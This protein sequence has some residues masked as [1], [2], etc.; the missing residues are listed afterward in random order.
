ML[1]QL[2]NR[3]KVIIAARQVLSVLPKLGFV[4]KPRYH[5]EGVSFIVP[6]KDEELWIRPCLLSIQD[7][8]DEILVVDSSV[9]DK[10][11]EIIDS[12][13]KANSKIKHIRFYWEGK[14]SIA[15]S[16]HIGLVSAKYKWIF[17]WDSDQVAKST[18]ALSIWVNRLKLLDKNRYYAID[19]P[20]INFEGDLQHQVKSN[21]FGSYES[22]IFT[23]SP[24]LKWS[25][26][27]GTRC[28]QVVGDSIWGARFPPWYNLQRWHDPFIYHCNIKSPRRMLTRKFWDSYM[29][30]KDPRFNSLDDYTAYRVQK[31]WN[32]TVEEA[33]LKVMADLYKTLIPYDK[34]K[35][36]ELPEIL[37]AVKSTS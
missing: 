22:R 20:R 37:Q 31:D 33:Q 7:V 12:L 17:K 30:N 9:E 35:Y 34:N 3:D 15:L 27:E 2:T 5:E 8:A 25:L 19:T 26:K 14:N 36:G 10:T 6:V 16:N 24:E 28:E 13:A 21:P 23:W 18:D 32:M 29:A 1:D 11:T 4:K